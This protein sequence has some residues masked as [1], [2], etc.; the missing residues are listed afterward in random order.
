LFAS[1]HRQFNADPICSM[2]KSITLFASPHQTLY[3]NLYRL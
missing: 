3:K 1:C 2:E